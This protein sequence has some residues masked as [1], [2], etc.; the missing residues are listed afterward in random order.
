MRKIFIMVLIACLMLSLVACGGSSDSK[1]TIGVGSKAWTEQLTLGSITLQYL[2]A[3]GYDV[4][5][6]T[7]LGETPVLR[8]ALTSGEIDM[9]WEYTGTTLMANMKHDVITDPDECYTTVKTWDKKENNIVWLDPA[10]ANNTYILMVRQMFAEEKNLETISDLAEFIKS[11]NDIRLGAS[12]EFVE[13]PDGIAGLEALYDFEFDR[14]LVSSMAVGITYEA[15]K[16]DQVDVSMGF[17]TDGRI[18]AMNFKV[19]DDDM[20]FFPVY[21]PA[22]IVRQEILDAYPELAADL[23]VLPALLSGNVL[24]ELNKRVD[25]DGLEPEEVAKEFL[26]KNNLID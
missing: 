16:N 5:D 7:G 22:P 2:E 15:L 11:G 19:L 17:G 4:E 14:D 18:I 25:V 1:P 9:Y 10:K 12:I 24:Q 13:R 8:P 23:N 26:Q 6:R 3:K 20:K 21:N